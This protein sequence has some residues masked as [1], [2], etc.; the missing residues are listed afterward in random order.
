MQE[1]TSLGVKIHRL[2][3]F[4]PDSCDLSKQDQAQI[5]LFPRQLRSDV[6]QATGLVQRIKPTVLHG[7]Q[8]RSA[9]ACGWVG[10][11]N[12]IDRIV[13]SARNMQP[14]KRGMPQRYAEPLFQAFCQNPNVTMTANA[15]A[16]GEDYEAW[17]GLADGSIQTLRNGMR[18][19]TFRSV[20]GL[21]KR[22]RRGAEITI[23]GVFR[24][25]AN[26]R[27]LLWLRTL[28]ALREV[29]PVKINARLIGRGPF[30]DDILALAEELDF[31]DLQM[32]D[33]LSSPEDIY[34][35]MDVL[36]LMSRV[37]G[38]PNVVLEAHATGLPVAA[39]DVGGVREALCQKTPSSG[40][41]LPSDPNAREAAA[42]LNDWLP[43]AM[44]SAEKVRQDFIEDHFG[45][46][47]LANATQRLY[48]GNGWRDGG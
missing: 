47:A 2:A 28:A 42:L 19:E 13:L 39:C 7:W 36:L 25:A 23:G 45:M 1:L 34:G 27:P 11:T 10:L 31:A 15:R 46:T 41:L 33:S 9:L 12:N 32:A 22:R 26:K 44:N 5:A 3:E 6:I 48:Q 43:E 29:S 38:L 20:H 14:Q 18:T 21:R 8:D 30:R 40:L 4:D 17:L 35:P 37:E 24:L 16:C